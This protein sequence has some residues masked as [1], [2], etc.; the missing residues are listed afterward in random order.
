MP[1]TRTV[2]MRSVLSLASSLFFGD[3]PL[4]IWDRS[5]SLARAQRKSRFMDLGFFPFSVST[6]RA[7]PCFAARSQFFD[8]P[9]ACTSSA[10]VQL[11]G[12]V[13]FV[14]LRGRWMLALPCFAARY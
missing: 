11:F 4:Q 14:V 3:I 9:I 7:L 10:Q 2:Y 5:S 6:A 8:I 13:T 12:L 1:R